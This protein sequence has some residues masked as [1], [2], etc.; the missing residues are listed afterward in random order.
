MCAIGALKGAIGAL[1]G[2]TPVDL[3]TDTVKI[4]GMHFS[5][6]VTL[7]EERNFLET[8]KKMEKILQIWRMRG[9]TLQ[10][11]I[12]VFKTL[13]ISKLVYCSYLSYVPKS[14][15]DLVKK[16]QKEFVWSDKPA[17]IKHNTMCNSYEQ[18][19]LQMSDIDLKIDA[20]HLSWVRRL[21]EGNDHQWKHIP[22]K[23][24]REYS[25]CFFPAFLPSTF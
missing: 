11:K 12:T 6:N 16:M 21:F 24:F 14:I 25:E 20:L 13:V 17:K 2:F 23:C 4:L 10:G 1:Y 18:G 8:G 3:T 5:Y 22:R 9:L 19:G 7:H 15:I